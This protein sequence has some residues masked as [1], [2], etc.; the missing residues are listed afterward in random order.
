MPVRP[1]L[2]RRGSPS[3]QEEMPKLDMK[4]APWLILFVFGGGLLALYYAGIGYFPEVTWQDALTYMA[5]MAI[6]GG[7]LLV[8]YSFLLFVPGA[9]WS[10]L[11]IHDFQLHKV[12]MMGARAWEPC[13]W[14][15][16]KKILLPFALFMAFCHFL[17]F[18]LK[19]D[20]VNLAGFVS[21]G[22]AASLT[23]VAGLLWRDLSEGLDLEAKKEVVRT[24]GRHRASVAAFHIPLFAMFILKAIEPTADLSDIGLWVTA[25]LPLVSFAGPFLDTRHKRRVKSASS[26]PVP[27]K[28]SLLCRAILA[29]CV[30]ALL[31]LVALWFFY[32]IYRGAAPGASGETVRVPLSLLILCTF[33]VIVA[34]LAVSVL[35]HEHRRAAL[36]ASFLAA[37]LLLGAGQLLPE[38]KASLPAKIMQSFGFGA[39]Q[40]T[41]VLTEKG[42]RLLCEQKIPVKLEK[43]GQLEVDPAKNDLDKNRDDFCS[44]KEVP[45]NPSPVPAGTQAPMATGADKPQEHS[46]PTGEE[47]PRQEILARA[48]GL[49]ILSRLGSEY[50]LRFEGD[51]APITVAVPKSEVV[52]WSVSGPLS[53]PPKAE[54]LVTTRP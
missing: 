18:L 53:P 32:R 41:L 37:L 6:I 52:S 20:D 23:A 28:L 11:L 29:F 33:V 3:A 13:V 24:I 34:N 48:E 14:S 49:T 36:L 39:Q 45:G 10:E 46:A 15:V 7:S 4:I 42:G 5:L 50:L 22:A 26:T 17:L 19:P 2:Y 12:L 43:R 21:V 16:M 30:A 54:V 25:L 51:P 8:A 35:F 40:A 47:K 9:I 44:H 38:Q 31:S 27:D 1:N